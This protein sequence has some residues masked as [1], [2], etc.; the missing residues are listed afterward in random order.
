MT[1]LSFDIYL[2][3]RW[4]K[5]MMLMQVNKNCGLEDGRLP[6]GLA[7]AEEVQAAANMHTLHLTPKHNLS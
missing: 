6:P 4:Q 3:K 5:E 1:E 2:S 7:S